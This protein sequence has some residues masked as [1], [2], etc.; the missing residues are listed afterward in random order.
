MPTSFSH[1]F[2]KDEKEVIQDYLKKYNLSKERSDNISH[3]AKTLVQKIRNHKRSTGG[4]ESFMQ[5]F[6]LDTN[7]GIALMTLAEALLRVPDKYTARK[8]IRDKV[9]AANWLNGE[10]GS[11]DWVVK[12]AGVGLFMSSKALDSVIAKVGEPFMHQAMVKAMQI[13]GKEFVFGTDIED[14][15]KNSTSHIQNNVRISYDMLGEGARTAIDA[16]RYFENYEHAIKY[17]AERT[18]KHTALR[19]GISVKLSAIHPRYEYAQEDRCIMEMSAQ[20]LELAKLCANNNIAMTID[21]E[22]SERLNTSVQIIENILGLPALKDWDGFGLA[23]QAYNKAA[24]ALIDHIQERAEHHKIKTHIRL[25]KGAYWDS[26]IKNSQ[27]GGLNHFPV[28]TRKANTDLSY[29]I[30]AEKMCLSPNIFPMFATHNA[31]SICAVQDIAEHYKAD[32]ELQKLFGM[33]D[34]LYDIIRSEKPE[35]KTSIYAPVG[36]HQDLLPYLVRRLLEN[37]ANSSFVNKVMKR[38]EPIEPLTQ[39]PATQIKKDNRFKHTRIKDSKD[40][41]WNESPMGR[42]NSSGLD[43]NAPDVVS[44]LNKKIASFHKPYIAAPIICGK[45][46]TETLAEEI[47]NPANTSQV[48]GKMHP[49]TSRQIKKAFSRAQDAFKEWNESPAEHRAQILEKIASLYEENKEELYY[50]LIHEAGKT[51]P[52]AQDEIREAIDFCRYYAAQG[53][54]LFKE[55]GILLPGPTGEQNSLSHHGRGCFV[56][57]SPWNFPLAIYTGQIVAALMAGNTVLAKPAEQ[58]PIIASFALKLMHRAGIPQNVLH[59]ILGDGRIGDM[60]TSNID[61]AGV[62]FT[63]SNETARLINQSLANKKGAIV[64]LIAETGGQNAMIVDSSALPEQVADDAIRSAFGSAGQR[65][66]A[67][68]IL[69]LQ[70]DSADK[71]IRMLSGM[72]HE[73]NLGDPSKLSTDIGPVIDE[74]ALHILNHYRV[75]LGGMAKEISSASVSANLQKQGHFF[76]PSIWE[77]HNLHGMQKEVFGPVLH[78]LKYDTHELH[79]ILEQLKN[80]GYG[81]TLGI[82]SRIE[83]FQ[84]EVIQAMPVGNVYINRSMTGAIVGSQPFGGLGLSGTGPK[85]G[86][87]SYLHRFATERTISIDTTAAG[88]NASLVSLGE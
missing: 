81:L 44:T 79:D 25:V 88:G 33:G 56:C 41:F 17:I 47:K 48:I 45:E 57:I 73:M 29:L 68:R 61:T 59:L 83:S 77:I 78:I 9:V 28:F 71:V 13:L 69:L 64:P 14:A 4:L 62:A 70:R 18:D 58:T 53:R 12:A 86:G 7:E 1:Y 3:E 51:I 15:L 11:N 72:I 66:S 20:L 2:H 85:A 38:D 49:S 24:P 26:E 6:S 80:L 54:T 40:L 42:L 32:F 21:A 55:E 10:G 65:C 39:D 60:L 23:V 31:H 63:G 36:P 37:G 46:L 35:I 75:E 82:H 34:S 8:L 76:A 84:K 19:P 43:L 74:E 27:I 52:D 30:C 67:L 50:L 16:Q 22:E 5:E 87:P